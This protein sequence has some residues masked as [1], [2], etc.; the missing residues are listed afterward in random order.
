MTTH[1]TNIQTKDAGKPNCKCQE[2]KSRIQQLEHDVTEK[3]DECM[4]WYRQF[5]DAKEEARSMDSVNTRSINV[6]KKRG[7]ET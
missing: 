4:F 2:Y 6:V 1:N 7:K 5:Q 3:E